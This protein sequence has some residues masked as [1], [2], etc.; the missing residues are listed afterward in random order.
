MTVTVGG[1]DTS[2]LRLWC[3]NGAAVY[4]KSHQS[5]SLGYTFHLLPT[6]RLAWGVLSTVLFTSMR[7]AEGVAPATTLLPVIRTGNLSL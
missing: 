7:V 6:E 5:R 4:Y 1:A 3:R 2:C